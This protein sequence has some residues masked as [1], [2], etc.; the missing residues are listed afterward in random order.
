[1]GALPSVELLPL[2]HP[3]WPRPAATKGFQVKVGWSAEVKPDEWIRLDLDEEDLLSILVA[4]SYP[5]DRRSHIPT[6]VAY[7]LLDLECQRLLTAKLAADY[8]ME[9]DEARTKIAEL[10]KRQDVLLAQLGSW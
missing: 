7:Q 2:R 4:V 3:R 10:K 1:M 5:L 8:G 9:P 6:H